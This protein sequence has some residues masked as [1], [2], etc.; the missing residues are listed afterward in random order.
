MKRDSRRASL[1]PAHQLRVPLARFGMP[2]FGLQGLDRRRGTS[3]RLA[4]AKARCLSSCHEIRLEPGAV[5]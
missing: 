1:V 3:V 5:Y 2:S 4:A